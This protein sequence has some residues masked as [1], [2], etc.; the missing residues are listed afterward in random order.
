MAGKRLDSSAGSSTRIGGKRVIKIE[1]DTLYA[2]FGCGTP[3]IEWVMIYLPLLCIVIVLAIIRHKK[4]RIT[5]SGQRIL[6]LTAKLLVLLSLVVVSAALA[7]GVLFRE[8]EGVM[9]G[10]KEPAPYFYISLDALA[11]DAFGL[12]CLFIG[13][14]PLLCLTVALI[15]IAKHVFNAKKTGGVDHQ[16]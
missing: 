5:Q 2:I 9:M 8:G 15:M 12:S 11:G 3:M 4:G 10:L 16:A 13:Y 1:W 14:V 7:L 6:L